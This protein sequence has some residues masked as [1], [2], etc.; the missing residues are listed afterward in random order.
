MTWCKSV[1]AEPLL[2]VNLGTGMPESAATL[3]EYCNVEKGTKWSEL[4]RKHGIAEAHRV[5]YWC[6]GNEMDRPWQIG[7]VTAP[8]YGE[9][10]APHSLE[11]IYNLE[12][13]L[14][15]GGLINSLVRN[16]NRVRIGCLARLVNVIAPIMTNESGLYGQ[17]IYYLYSWALQYARGAVLEVLQLPWSTYEVPGCGQVQY[18]DM[19]GTFNAEDGTVS[20]FILNR[21]LEKAHV[22]ELNSESKA[23][24]RLLAG[25]MLTGSDLK[26]VNGFD[27][28][29]RVAP[30]AAEKPSMA[31]SVMRL[32]V[33]AKSYSVY[34]WAI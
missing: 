17:T 23:A 1:G 31:G 33:P 30:Q 28:P 7:H 26:A 14:L 15:V 27:K 12:D 32:E 34:Q 16:S 9:K 10:T 3:V 2:A 21:D 13:A 4:R 5:K 29:D 8:E 24:S 20:V 22:L 6:L 19:A 18:L 25:F 11:E